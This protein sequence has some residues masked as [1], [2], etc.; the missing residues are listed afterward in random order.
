M[1]SLK[2]GSATLLESPERGGNV[3]GAA[4]CMVILVI[5]VHRLWPVTLKNGRAEVR[6]GSCQIQETL[7]LD[8]IKFA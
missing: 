1:H 8:N 5:T 7:F 3:G 2:P 4:G 6:P